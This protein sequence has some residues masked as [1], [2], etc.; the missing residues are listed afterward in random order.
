MPA[1][2]TL[3]TRVQSL[4]AKFDYLLERY[5]LSGLIDKDEAEFHDWVKG[6]DI[7]LN[8]INNK[9]LLDACKRSWMAARGKSDKNYDK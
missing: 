2:N 9:P 1:F 3:E 6:T 4:E 5:H 7:E 8:G